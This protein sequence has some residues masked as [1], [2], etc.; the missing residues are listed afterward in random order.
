MNDKNSDTMKREEQYGKASNGW[1]ERERRDLPCG[2][3]RW[4]WGI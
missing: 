2:I 1:Y 4:G 3:G